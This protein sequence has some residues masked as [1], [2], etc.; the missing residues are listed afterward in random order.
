MT[1][2]ANGSG[3]FPWPDRDEDGLLLFGEAGSPI[4]KSRHGMALVQNSGKA[5][6]LSG[7]DTQMKT[8]PDSPPSTPTALLPYCRDCRDL[9]EWPKRWMGEENDLPPGRRLVEYFMPFLLHLAKSGLSRRT[10]HMRI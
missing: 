3:S 8:N 4:D 1:T 5:H 7:I 9:S 10:I 6:E 2:R